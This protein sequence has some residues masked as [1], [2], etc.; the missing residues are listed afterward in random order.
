MHIILK[1]L[2]VSALSMAAMVA[3]SQPKVRLPANDEAPLVCAAAMQTLLGKSYQFQKSAMVD[4]IEVH[5][6]KS[7][8]GKYANSCYLQGSVV[9]WRTDKSPS[10]FQ[11]G[12]WR[13]HTFDEKVSW[14]REGDKI[15]IT[16]RS[17][18]GSNESIQKTYAASQLKRTAKLPQ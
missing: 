5:Q 10:H 7:P 18:I 1:L 17:G 14:I 3:Q 9:M 4:G 12:R 11:P 13:T 16:V 6:F 15:S 2:A 8:D